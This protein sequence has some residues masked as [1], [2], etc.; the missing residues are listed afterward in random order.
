MGSYVGKE[1][2]FTVKI[3]GDKWIH[4]GV[5]SAGQKL[6]EIWKRVK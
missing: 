5:L 4:S 2:K 6:E 3:E 1:Q